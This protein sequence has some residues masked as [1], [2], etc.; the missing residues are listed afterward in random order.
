MLIFH[1][2]YVLAWTAAGSD[3][4]YQSVSISSSGQY[5]IAVAISRG[6]VIISD[7]YGVSKWIQYQ[8]YLPLI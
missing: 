4:I 6:G 7:D 5:Q 8:S 3:W 2:F 1:I